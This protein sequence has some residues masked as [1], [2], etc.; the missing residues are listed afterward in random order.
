[1]LCT[2]A[3]IHST[4]NTDN[5]KPARMDECLSHQYIDAPKNVKSNKLWMQ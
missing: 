3:T 1:M 5:T 4:Y 2:N